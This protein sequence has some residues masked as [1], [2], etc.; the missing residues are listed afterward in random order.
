MSAQRLQLLA[1]LARGAQRRTGPALLRARALLP[2]GANLAPTARLLHISAARRSE[3]I[4][5]DVETSAPSTTNNQGGEDQPPEGQKTE[6]EQHII[7]VL[8]NTFA[9][10]MLSVTDVSGGCGAF[11]Q[12]ILSS[13]KFNGLT[14]LKQHRLVQG[15]LKSIIKDIHGLQVRRIAHRDQGV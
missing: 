7:S 11:Y 13:K 10:A 3:P 15:E 6:G 12:I 8:E 14:T 9:P 2:S 5:V 1:P 4:G